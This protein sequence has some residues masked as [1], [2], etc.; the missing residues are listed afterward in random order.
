M[1]RC[2]L[3]TCKKKMGYMKFECKFCHTC[4][5]L[6]HQLPEK[7]NCNVRESD[8]YEAYKAINNINYDA[9]TD[10]E[11]VKTDN[12]KLHRNVEW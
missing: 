11:R 5:C 12:T 6:K 9:A 3:S 10:K 8:A 1:D 7:H 4:H 2:T